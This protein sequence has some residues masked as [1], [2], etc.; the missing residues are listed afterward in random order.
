MNM[1]YFCNIDLFADNFLALKKKIYGQ[2]DV[3]KKRGFKVNLIIINKL[4]FYIL[5]INNNTKKGYFYLNDENLYSS[6][7]NLIIKLNPKIIYVRHSPTRFFLMQFYKL[8]K[9]NCRKT[10]MI[11]EFP[12]IPYDDEMRANENAP[13]TVESIIAIDRFYRQ[14][15]KSFFNISVNFNGL[16]NVFGLKSIPIKNG[17]FLEYIPI[18]SSKIN[19]KKEIS[20][21]GLAI[22]HNWHGYE[23]VLNGIYEYYNKHYKEY[24]YL[25]KLNIVGIGPSRYK[26]EEICNSYKINDYVSFLGLL[27]GKDLDYTFENSDIA[28][29]SLGFYKNGYKMGSP[30]KTK[31]YCARGIPFIIG[32]DDLSFNEDVEYIMKVD[33]N[34]SNIDMR[35]VI[36]FY[37]AS[38]KI[39]NLTSIMRKYAEENLTWE[40]SFENLFKELKLQ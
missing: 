6:I 25:I 21:I 26:L 30:L 14:Q 37:E 33:N 13:D 28:L 17:I 16:K 35:Q 23:R 3:F 40:K 7:L 38:K 20:L 29:G 1:V 34:D 39:N 15:L 11:I 24:K 2:I 12:T 31:E 19:N 9:E 18:K 4:K 22:L 27:D 8:I 10:E 32:Y 5:D 36:K